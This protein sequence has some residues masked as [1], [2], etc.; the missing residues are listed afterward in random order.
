MTS[1]IAKPPPEDFFYPLTDQWTKPFWDAAMERRLTAPQC[2]AC[3]TFRM[4]PTPFCPHCLSQ[5]IG[6]PTLSGRGVIYSF[7][8]V[9]RSV[10]AG[11]EGSL[12]YAP[13]L[14]ELPDAG[15]VRLITNVIDTPVDTIKI[16]A[17]VAVAW[18]QRRDGYC[19]PCFT[20]DERR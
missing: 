19:T 3:L 9:A 15:R 20:L 1:D 2:R 13:A 16:G 14:V 5:E 8:I 18:R 10:M 17:S 7:T 11:M 4:P 6:W 12:P